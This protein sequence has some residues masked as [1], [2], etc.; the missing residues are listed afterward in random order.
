[1]DANEQPATNRRSA[2]IAATMASFLT[3]FLGSSINV[4]LPAIG[5]DLHLT[6]VALSWVASAFILASA[7]CLVPFGH[8][9]DRLGRRRVFL[10]GMMAFATLTLACGFAP[11]GPVLILLRVLQGI[12]AAAVFGTG[13][14]ILTSVYPAGERGRVLGLNAAAVYAG[15]SLGP[16]V[17]GVL[18]ER[19]GWPS[20]FFVSAPIGCATVAV[21]WRGLRG[22][23]KG[24]TG[25]S[26]DG[27]GAV[28][29]GV[30]LVAL[31]SGLSRV[32]AATGFVLIAGSLVAFAAFVAWERRVAHP[33]LNVGLLAS[34]QVFARSNLAALINYSANFA[35][36]FLLSLYLQYVR[37]LSPGRA[38]LVLLTQSVVMAA[39]SPAAGLLSDRWEPRIVASI[40]MG[41]SVAGLAWLCLLGPDTPIT[42]IV[43][44]LVVL[45]A[46]FG[47]FSSPNTNA[48]MGAV[49]KRHYGAASA[50]L[51]TM[52]LVGQMLSLGVAA[53]ALAAFVGREAITA[54]RP[55]EF[56]AGLHLAFVIFTGL[57]AAG[58]WAS[59]SRGN[60]RTA[61]AS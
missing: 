31:M 13:L 20:I 16:F 49:E 53:A 19:W 25:G 1:M 52:R 38:G 32:P 11:S 61:P 44:A 60:L 57:G 17:G 33:V 10:A 2:L 21:A 12:G 6:P 47:L 14:A 5:H 34:N 36:T 43:V 55:A 26:F 7:V 15:L 46:G 35:T 59:L 48:V 3:P 41:L 29:Y 4:A 24:E 56:L 39:V 23:W 18:T 8:L 51:G 28:L 45:G 30:A 58:I 37:G 50:T 40:G 42:A 9:A 54:A 22:E 27:I